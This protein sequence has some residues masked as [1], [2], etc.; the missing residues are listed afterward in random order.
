LNTVEFGF[1]IRFMLRFCI[2]VILGVVGTGVLF[3]LLSFR[4]LS[5]GY[6]DAVYTIYNLKRVVLPTLFASLESILLLGIVTIIIAAMSLFF[7]HK[8][9]GPLFRISRD[10]E[11]IAAGDLTVETRLRAKDQIAELARIVNGLTQRLKRRVKETGDAHASVEAATARLQTILTGDPSAEA[12]REAADNLRG[13]IEKLKSVVRST[14][15][16]S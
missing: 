3:Y 15:G 6:G 16:K 8:I 7:S 10:L 14:E 4:Q 1:K 12:L 11:T 5:T 13:D 9:A 2:L